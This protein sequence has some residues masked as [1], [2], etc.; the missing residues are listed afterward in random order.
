MGLID[1]IADSHSVSVVGLEKN[2]GKTE[3]LNYIVRNLPLDRVKVAVTSIGVD[4][5][6]VDAVTGTHKPE[7]HLR[8]GMVFTTSE[9]HYRNRNIFSD[10]L[11]VSDE[12]TALGRT[13]TARALDYGKVLLSGPSTSAG[14]ERWMK[15]MDRFGAG[16]KIIDGA[17]SRLSSASPSVSEAMVLAT[18]A[19]YSANLQELVTKTSYVVEL[20]MAPLAD[21]GVLS[22]PDL[23]SGGIWRLRRDGTAELLPD[24]GSALAL[25]RIK[26]NLV[27]DCSGIYVSGAVTDRLAKRLLSDGAA[28]GFQLVARDFTKIFL[29]RQQY[30]ML[31]SAG[32]RIRVLQRSRLL[33]VTVNPVS[34]NGMVLDSDRLCGELRARID[35]PVYD[36]F[37]I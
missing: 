25:S 31:V 4:G 26:D 24:A 3:C 28:D 32:V 35:V 17:I 7:I 20:V 27:R 29:S 15:A 18:G 22:L 33:A 12:R 11:D 37:K 2:T 16:L 30:R 19:A 1:D 13:V 8:E 6:T 14:L 9:K 36:L 5:E 10:L 23:S 34:P 21:E